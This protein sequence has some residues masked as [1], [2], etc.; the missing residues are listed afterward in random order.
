MKLTSILVA[1]CMTFSS[2]STYTPSS[3]KPLVSAAVLVAANQFARKDP[4]NVGKIL[5]IAT[6]LELAADATDNTLT[7]E[8]FVTLVQKVDVEW[9]ILGVALYDFYAQN[10]IIPEQYSKHSETLRQL[11]TVLRDSVIGIVVPSA[12]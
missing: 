5:D 7:K 10:V 4:K 9:A 11:S 12:K 1:L 3:Y 6:V 2:C 8:Q